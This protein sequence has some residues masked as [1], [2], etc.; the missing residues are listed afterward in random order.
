MSEDG[1]S[2]LSCHIITSNMLCNLIP[3]PIKLEKNWNSPL[4][5]EN[6]YKHLCCS[7]VSLSQIVS[8]VLLIMYQHSYIN[9]KR[10]YID[11]SISTYER[12]NIVF[13]FSATSLHCTLAVDLIA[14]IILIHVLYT[15]YV[16]Q[17]FFI[18]MKKMHLYIIQRGAKASRVC[19]KD[20]DKSRFFF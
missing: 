5:I 19:S 9:Q 12:H 11:H 18:H 1:I 20:K 4:L 8:I 7:I 2:L 17:L 14:D 10:S 3:F 15:H 16:Q 6:L 13:I